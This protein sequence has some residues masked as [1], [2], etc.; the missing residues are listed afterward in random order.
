MA[1][2]EQ[3]FCFMWIDLSDGNDRSLYQMGE[4][5]GPIDDAKC[6]GQVTNLKKFTERCNGDGF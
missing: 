2:M 1:P 6:F 4:K 5:E 3:F